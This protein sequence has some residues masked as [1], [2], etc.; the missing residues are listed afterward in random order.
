MEVYNRGTASMEQR[1]LTLETNLVNPKEPLLNSSCV[2]MVCC[3][4][5]DLLK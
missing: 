3:V 1:I 2:I 5:S 4:P